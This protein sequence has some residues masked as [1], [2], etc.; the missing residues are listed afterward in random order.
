M[1]QGFSLYVCI[2][3]HLTA[4]QSFM[5]RI[6]KDVSVKATFLFFFFQLG[7][8]SYSKFYGYVIKMDIS[9]FFSNITTTVL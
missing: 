5:L 1:F 8:F 3:F 6:L 7:V 2:A 9:K 4:N